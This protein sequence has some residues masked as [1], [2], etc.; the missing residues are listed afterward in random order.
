[1]K[2]TTTSHAKP[3]KPTAGRYKNYIL[4]AIL[5]FTLMLY[6]PV[7]DNDF[8]AG[9]DYTIVVNN[10]DIRSLDNIPK[11]F[12]QPYHSMYCPVK[13]ISHAIDYRF[14]LA[15][16]GGYHFFSLLYH[17]VNVALVFTLLWLLFANVGGAA[18]GALL[19]AVHPINAEAV[20]WLTGRGDLLYGGF[21][22]GGLIA[23]IK[24]I[25]SGYRSKYFLWT[26]I[27]FALSGLSKASAMTFPLTLLA[28][29]WFYR[30]KLFSWR[31]VG[32]KAPFF[33]GAL[34]L[35]IGA[36]VLRSGH[37]VALSDYFSHFTGI[38]PFVIFIYPLTFYLVK[39]FVPASLALPYP[40]PFASELPLP[41]GFYIYPFI[42][43][44]LAVLILRCKTLRRPLMFALLVYLCAL[45]SA[46]RL[47][48]MLGTIAA[49]R[50]F[51]VAMM[52]V[53]LFIAWAYGYLR[54]HRAL[55]KRRAFPLFLAAVV[56]FAGMCSILTGTRIK[57]FKDGITL[58]GDAHAKYP[59]HATPLY[60]LAG[61]YMQAGDVD[62]A[63]QTIGKITEL[64]PGSEDA[65]GFQTDLLL[66]AGRYPEALRNINRL[67]Q[68]R[69]EKHYY[70]PKAELHRALNQPDS[71][72][73]AAS[74][75][76]EDASDSAAY[77]PGAKLAVQGYI[78]AQRYA[79]ALF[80]IDSVLTHYPSETPSFLLERA[81]VAAE[82]ND[83]NAAINDLLLLLQLQPDNGLACLN[84][85]KLYAAAGR[86]DEACRYW[87]K[88]AELQTPEAAELLQNCRLP[89]Q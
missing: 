84:L 1:M 14:S 22:F 69:P 21:Y 48:P 32:E 86:E 71:M 66:S 62:K 87:Q 77:V 27:L 33:A 43:V 50:Y 79:D 19:F 5:F 36:I 29:D 12:A 30:R 45:V 40:H 80:A 58:F 73:A 78:M 44:A 82:L 70:L 16:P 57:V 17:L 18:V 61:G 56:A 76:M 67:I 85:G 7:L 53:V 75:L 31:V 47:T 42:L 54:E 20:C 4:A 68:L 35:G 26:F 52:G 60:E 28:L 74:I 6:R 25:K 41:P 59:A 8:V 23:Y 72:L 10:P 81:W 15:R 55:L 49:D 88:A 38:D 46:M 13:M 51:Y 39:F 63:I 89:V 37:S 65:W 64:L 2:K 3:A 11:F 34:A 9:D 83:T 24:Y